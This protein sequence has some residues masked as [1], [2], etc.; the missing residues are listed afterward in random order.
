MKLFLWSDLTL[1]VLKLAIKIC[2]SLSGGRPIDSWK[3]ELR[4]RPTIEDG[5]IWKFGDLTRL[6]CVVA[7]GSLSFFVIPSRFRR[8]VAFDF[9]IVNL[10]RVLWETT[11]TGPSNLLVFKSLGLQFLQIF[12]LFPVSLPYCGSVWV[13]GKSRVIWNHMPRTGNTGRQNTSW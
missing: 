5:Q 11:K 12:K 3:E 13:K 7:C 1:F 9:C 8:L 10:L 4:L 6:K 2:A